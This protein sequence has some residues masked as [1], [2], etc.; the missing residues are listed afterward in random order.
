METATKHQKAEKLRNRMAG[1]RQEEA[2]YEAPT[3]AKHSQSM[4]QGFTGQR[5]IQPKYDVQGATL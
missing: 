1:S 2:P 4:A 3:P 5:L